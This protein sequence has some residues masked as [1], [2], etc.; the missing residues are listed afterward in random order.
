MQNWNEKHRNWRFRNPD[1]FRR[2]IYAARMLVKGAERRGIPEDSDEGIEGRIAR[3]R[4]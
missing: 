1:K 4:R 2:E 3:H